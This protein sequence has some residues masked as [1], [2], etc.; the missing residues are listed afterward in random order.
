MTKKEKE[1]LL[2]SEF[3]PV[4]TKDW[5]EK[6][7]ADLKGGDYDKKLVW[8]T[9]EGIKVKPY[10]RKE[11]IEKLEYQHALPG[12]F[13]F[14]SGNKTNSNAWEIRQD[15]EEPKPDKA[16][17]IATDALSRGADAIGFN[18]KEI[19]YEKEMKDLLE[20]IDLSK[21]AVH[22]TSASSFPVISSL[23]L[24][25]LKRRKIDTLTVKG[26]LNFDP[27]SYYLLYGK[28]YSS[29]NNNFDE[30]VSLIK[31]LKKETPLFKAI[32]I[33]G[34]Y[35]HN[36][37]ASI[38]QELAFSLASANEYLVQLTDRGLAV[39]DITPRMQFVF[40]MGSNYFMEI[41]KLRA[42]RILWSKIV[43]QY[44]PA[45]DNS[46]KMCI[47]AVTSLWNKSIYD[48]YVNM[49]RSTTEAMSAAIGCCDSMSV[50]PFDIT[51][52]NPEEFSERIARNTQLILRSE[53]YLDKV[54][55]PSAGSYYIEN[56]TDSIVDVTWKLFLDINDKGG[57]I[58]A[59]ESEFIKDD[60]E[61]ICQKRDMD[62]AMRKQVILGTNQHP[63]LK[64]NMIN[65]IKPHANINALGSLK[66]YRGAYAFEA[67]RLSTEVYEKDG[68]KRPSVFLFTF[69]KV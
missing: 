19:E 33:N 6:I 40:A 68:N 25:E 4:S 28:F 14:V 44:K 50:Q 21:V 62:I 10:Y 17:K 42:A 24:Q 59:V 9:T 32:T 31:E 54:I 63:N 67:L 47:H 2:F 34:Q 61:I 16:N 26:S 27:L 37:G 58:K 41:A 7:H 1:S 30:A 57:F 51:Y 38:V 64:E 56:L 69:G 18:A 5:E 60:I 13:P 52:K 11:D 35:F 66:Q 39:D 49:L 22:F 12:E 3:P 65:K 23:F 29:Q 43:E 20:G 46:M 8:K 45:N 36:A 48:P 15:I 55:D 53:S